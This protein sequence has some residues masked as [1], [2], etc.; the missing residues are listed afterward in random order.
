MTKRILVLCGGISK[1]RLI[2]LDTGKQVANELRKNRYKVKTCEPDY[3]L[4]KNIKLFKPDII[5]NALHGQFG[6]DGYIQTILETQKIPYTHSG[7]IASSIAMD[8]EISKKIFIKNKILTPKYIKFDYKKNKKNIIKIVEKK[9][10][11]PVVLKPINEGSSVHV[12]ICTKKNIVK[13]LKALS[14][15]NQILIEEFIGG[16][17]IQ[18]AIMGSKMLGAIELKPRRKF[19]DYEAKYNL[20]AKTKHIIPVS[21]NKKDLKKITSITHKAHKIIGCNGVTRSDFKFYRGK[22]YLLEINTQPGM[23]K[24]S[25]VPEIAS[26]A[27]INFIQLIKWILKDA[28]INR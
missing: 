2:S 15:Y 10:K 18:V 7:V 21:L 11:F 6:E 25:L 16:R 4:L 14:I 28:S 5:F 12:Y 13:N 9:L 8:K 22:F 1:E 27:G 20:N 3:T 26:Y 24:L 17:E 23:T 19:Y